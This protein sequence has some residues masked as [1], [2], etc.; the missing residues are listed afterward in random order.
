MLEAAADGAASRCWG[1]PAWVLLDR[2]GQIG[3]CN[4]AT[5]ARS[6]TNLHGA[7]EVSFVV[8]DPHPPAL[9]RC[10]D[11]TDDDSILSTSVTGADGAF[12]IGGDLI[13][14]LTSFFTG[15]A[16][17]HRRSTS[18]PDLNYPVGIHS[19][20]VAVLSYSGDS[21]CLVVVPNARA[22]KSGA[23][24]YKVHIFS[25]KTKFWSIRVVNKMACDM[26]YMCCPDFELE[27]AKVFTVGGNSLAWVDLRYGILMCEGVNNDSPVMRFIQ[28]PQ[29]MP[30]NNKVNFNMN[31]DGTITTPLDILRDVTFNDDGTFRFIEMESHYLDSTKTTVLRWTINIF[32]KR[33]IGSEDW[34]QCTS[35]DSAKITPASSCIP[36]LFPDIWDSRDKRLTLDKIIS[37]APTLDQYHDDVVY[38]TTSKLDC[39]DLHGWV[40]AIDING[41][42]LDKLV[43]FTAHKYTLRPFLQ[44]SLSNYFS[45]A[46]GNYTI[47]HSSTMHYI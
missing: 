40:L 13:R 5:T 17:E 21:H 44:C 8:V 35:V 10:P 28:L 26:L 27:H 46:L 31:P 6:M 1:F 3:S 29:L 41:H 33:I 4:D 32:T 47:S 2:T 30:I 18:Y 22:E 36:H 12:L 7:I 25:G 14:S 43:P 20:H 16:P 15:P 45:T 42:K 34:E 23:V 38:M 37:F 11:L 24:N 19:N 39:C 9:F